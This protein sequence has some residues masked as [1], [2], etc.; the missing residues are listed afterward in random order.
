MI[1]KFTDFGFGK[2]G[3]SEMISEEGHQMVKHL[4]KFE[5]TD[6]LVDKTFNIAIVN[7]LWQIVSGSKFQVP[8]SRSIMY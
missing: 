6:F 4:A 2:S 3:M 7:I 5:G 8:V 1:C